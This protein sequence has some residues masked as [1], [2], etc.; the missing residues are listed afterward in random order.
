MKIIF[1]L[2]DFQKEHADNLTFRWQIMNREV[3]EESNSVVF[4]Y[5]KYLVFTGDRELFRNSVYPL[6]EDLYGSLEEADK[7]LTDFADDSEHL[8]WMEL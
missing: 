2:E 5:S 4:L 1:E 8:N 7:H 3:A 6:L